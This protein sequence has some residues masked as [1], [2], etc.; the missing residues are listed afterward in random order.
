[1]LSFIFLVLHCVFGLKCWN[2]KGG[3]EG[4]MELYKRSPDIFIIFVMTQHLSLT[5]MALK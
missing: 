3:Q 1:M 4:I 5:S 2:Y